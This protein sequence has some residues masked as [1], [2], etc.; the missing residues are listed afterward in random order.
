MRRA[1]EAWARTQDEVPAARAVD[2]A[3][4]DLVRAPWERE[5]LPRSTVI[6]RY[7]DAEGDE[8]AK[9]SAV[10]IAYALRS[11]GLRGDEE[12]LG[13]SPADRAL[14]ARTPDLGTLIARGALSARDSARRCARDIERCEA[15]LA[16]RTARAEHS[17]E[18]ARRRGAEGARRPH[19]P[20]PRPRSR[21][22]ERSQRGTR[23]TY[24]PRA[25]DTGPVVPSADGPMVAHPRPDRARVV[26]CHRAPLVTPTRPA[27]SRVPPRQ[28]LP[29]GPTPDARTWR[30]RSYRDADGTRRWAISPRGD[31]EI[32]A[33]DALD[34]CRRQIA[35]EVADLAHDQSPRVSPDRAATIADLGAGPH[36]MS[37]GAIT[38]ACPLSLRTALRDAVRG[39]RA[40]LAAPTGQSTDR[41]PARAI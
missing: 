6:L 3:R 11:R 34:L 1:W 33:R 36:M 41:R 38:R 18:R 22:A 21:R 14:V 32:A 2:R 13:L 4:D 24:Q 23:R 8:R 20:R 27:R 15:W 19:R 10:A 26:P 37:I 30:A 5:I 29:A 9:V 35:R 12:W 17:A 7:R 39:A 16:D 28:H 40:L 31:R 25:R